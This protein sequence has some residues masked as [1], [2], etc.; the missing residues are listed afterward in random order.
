MK[1]IF[2]VD[3]TLF[4]ASKIAIPAFQQV[5]TYFNKQYTEAELKD[6]LGRPN[7]EIWKLLLPEESEQRRREAFE[8]MDKAEVTLIN[9]GA[10]RLY[11]GVKTTLKRLYEQGHELYTLSNCDIKYLHTISEYYQIADYFTDLIC[12]GHYPGESKSR[13]L[14]R[15][16]K[17]SRDAVMIGDRFHDITAGRDNQVPAIWCSYGYGLRSE[18]DGEDDVVAAFPDILP[19]INRLSGRKK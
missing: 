19:I 7:T 6:M 18:I 9:E 2:D 11:E 1:I 13:I 8:L 3:G 10:G 15:I 12:V 5:L 4:E 16:L 14:A 17:G